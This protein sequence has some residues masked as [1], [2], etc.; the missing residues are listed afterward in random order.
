MEFKSQALGNGVASV[1]S[2]GIL[3][4]SELVLGHGKCLS[5]VL[6][7]GIGLTYQMMRKDVRH[8]Q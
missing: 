1:V 3:T 7:R 8:H 5:S 2:A 6:C 4:E